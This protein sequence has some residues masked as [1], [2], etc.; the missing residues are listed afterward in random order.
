MTT[1]LFTFFVAFLFSLAATP[2]VRNLALR[3]GL[4]DFPSTRKVHT[5]AVPRIGGVA[6]FASF[7]FALF[8]LF[9]LRDQ[10]SAA[11]LICHDSRIPGFVLGAV[12]IFALGL[13]DDIKSLSAVPKFLGQ[14]IAALMAYSWGLKITLVSMPFGGGLELG[15]FSLPLTLFWFVLVIN[16]INLIDG[17]DGLAAG[18][19]LFVC[20][21]MLFICAALNRIIEALAFASMAGTLLGFLRYNFNPA[22][23]FMGDSGSYFLGYCL[24]ALSIAGS[25]KGQVAT[26]MLIPV[27]ALGVPLI[28]TMWAPMRRFLLGRKIFQADQGHLHHQLVRLGFTH[29]RAVL[30]IYGVTILLGIAAIGLVH[31]QNDLAALIL[32]VLGMGVIFLSR[33]LGAAGYFTMHRMRNWFHDLSDEA[34]VSQER[35]S[36]LDH[37]LQISKAEDPATLWKAVCSTLETLAFDWAE[38][39]F[40]KEPLAGDAGPVKQ[41]FTWQRH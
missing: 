19:G 21:A 28:D 33:F 25:I 39:C 1:I 4:V 41:H 38:F 22:S 16:A 5:R 6:I 17:L 8:L 37:Q 7:F 36:F 23:I 3:H 2:M 14:V 31:A 9:L 35:R 11:G 12:I 32:F 24:A 29:R 13:Y 26:A 34:G 27:I 40:F 30:L 10:S 20:L 18:I 15:I